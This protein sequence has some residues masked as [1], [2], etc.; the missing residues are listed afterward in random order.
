MYKFVSEWR[1]E[2]ISQ[3]FL[4]HLYVNLGIEL[5]HPS[6]HLYLLGHLTGPRLLTFLS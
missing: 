2:E 1:L 6:E 4:F 5:R 3:T